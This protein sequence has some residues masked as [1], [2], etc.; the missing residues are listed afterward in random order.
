MM[1]RCGCALTG[2]SDLLAQ[3]TLVPARGGMF[4]GFAT[5]NYHRSL[6]TTAFHGGHFQR[7]PDDKQVKKSARLVRGEV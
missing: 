4:T 2:Q 6:T 7:K 3:W 5:I 1:G